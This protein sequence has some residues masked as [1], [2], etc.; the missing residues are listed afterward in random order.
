MLLKTILNCIHP[1][2]GFVYGKVRFIG[3]T[4]NKGIVVEIRHR[5]GSKGSCSICGKRSPGY[6]HL[7]KRQFSFI[8]IWNIAVSFAYAP[9]RV[10][11]S[12]HGVVVESLPWADGKHHTTT[13]F[14]VF[15]S[16]WARLLSW[17]EVAQRFGTT[18]DTVWGS[19]VSVVDYGL[20]HR[21]LGGV[22]SI[23]IDELAIWKG[24]NYI[25]MVYQIDEGMRRLLWIGKDRS[26]KSLLR[27]FQMF[28]PARSALIQYV[29]SD[30]WKPYLKVIARK[31]PQ[32]LN[33]LDRFH[34]MKKF[35]EAIDEIRRK[36]TRR[37]EDDGH[38]PVLTK[39]R[40]ILLKRPENLSDTQRG[41]LKT[42]LRYNLKSVRAYLLR[43][44]FQHFW[45]Y[46]SAT[47]AG[48]FLDDWIRRTMLSR[49]EPMKKV[50]RM[51]KNHKTLIMNWFAVHG[52]LSSGIVEAMNNTA[53]LTIR[54]SY[55]FRQYKTLEY[56]LYHKLGELPM[57][58]LTHEFF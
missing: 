12:D 55:G 17:Q 14:Q 5:L 50:A 29:C 38:K 21:V 1:I 9:R 15:L 52:K 3:D 41:R 31:I 35:G 8:P 10:S 53:K 6:D 25:T 37:L 24:H 45:T 23:G 33:I 42:L 28:G 46:K 43:E 30:M 34:I 54:K 22:K 26:A 16:Q 2:K 40:W 13:A 39:S 49:I 57:P 32:S 19:I 36:E 58:K 51:L 56:A 11:C 47:W 27:F 48:K 4:A 7:P 44:D 20:A 18:W